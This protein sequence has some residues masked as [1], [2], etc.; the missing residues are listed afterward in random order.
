MSSRTTRRGPTLAR[1]ALVLCGVVATTTVAVPS[2]LA[3]P[4]TRAQV[5]PIAV[6]LDSAEIGS[7]PGTVVLSGTV[8][9]DTPVQAGVFGSVAQVQGM[10]IARDFF[11]IET[12]VQCSSTPSAWTA[13]SAGALRVFLPQPTTID[14]YAQYCVGEACPTVSISETLTLVAAA[15]AADPAPVVDVAIPPMTN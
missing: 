4:P 3:A 15:P 7:A 9:C 5:Q 12:A 13:T 8:T 10:D 1:V 14:V 11:S 2:A 6:T